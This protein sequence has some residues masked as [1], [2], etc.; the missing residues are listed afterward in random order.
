LTKAECWSESP[1]L[2][3]G[4]TTYLRGPLAHKIATR[5]S[6]SFLV[7]FLPPMNFMALPRYTGQ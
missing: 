7:G 2:A 3:W 6:N 4:A 5:Y 1:A